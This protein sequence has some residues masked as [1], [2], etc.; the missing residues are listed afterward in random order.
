M[1]TGDADG[2]NLAAIRS[3]IHGSWLAAA[4]DLDPKALAAVKAGD[5]LLMSPEHFVKGAVAGRLQA[6]HAKDSTALPHGWVYCP[7]LAVT[8]ANI[9]AIIARQA[10]TATKE[11]A[12]RPEI[13]DIMRHLTTRMRPLSQAG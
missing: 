3:R 12:L 10:S 13:D 5:L 2:W 6:S 8:P 11:A 1:G 9:D 4:F 7:G